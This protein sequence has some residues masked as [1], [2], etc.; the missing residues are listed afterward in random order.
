MIVIIRITCNKCHVTCT[1][2]DYCYRWMKNEIVFQHVC[3]VKGI[4]AL[5]SNG[6]T[7]NTENSRR[8]RLA[9]FGQ[10]GLISD[11]HVIFQNS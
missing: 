7:H 2:V 8:A 3:N 9:S 11:P 5:E 1:N 6:H 4:F 10:L